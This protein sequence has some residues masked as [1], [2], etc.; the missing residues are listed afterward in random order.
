[1][2]LCNTNENDELER[3]K[4][5]IYTAVD[6]GVTGSIG[7]VDSDGNC[8]YFSHTPVTKEL[9]YTKKKSWVHLIDGLE[10]ISI[11]RNHPLEEYKMVLLER[12]MVNPMRW[13]ASMSAIRAFESTLTIIKTLKIPYRYIDSKEWQKRMLPEGLKGDELKVASLQVAKRMFPLIDF[14]G[15]KDADGLLMAEYA[16]L[17]K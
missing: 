8:I 2:T 10:L 1:M 6:N 3:P 5:T 4:R 17:S 12:P 13:T 9:N 14:K 16:R 15:F 11:F 7:M